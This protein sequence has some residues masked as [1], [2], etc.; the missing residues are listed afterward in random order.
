MVK[1][2]ELDQVIDKE[3]NTNEDFKKKQVSI[4]EFNLEKID[5]IDLAEFVD[6]IKQ[7]FQEEY[8][9]IDE[10]KK[11]CNSE[12]INE[13]KK[14]LNILTQQVFELC[15]DVI[16]K[17]TYSQLYEEDIEENK[18]LMKNIEFVM[19]L[20]HAELT[21]MCDNF[22]L[23][24]NFFYSRMTTYLKSIP[25]NSFVSKDDVMWKCLERDRYVMVSYFINE[26]NSIISILREIKSFVSSSYYIL[27]DK[28]R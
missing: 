4:F 20:L 24:N 23:E 15:N 10:K 22:Q 6:S 13:F 18:K 12:V 1:V 21:A 16:S 27:N 5:W 17:K 8:V 14:S 25:W 26:L 9:K 19:W 7:L 28:K 2:E 11:L 3:P